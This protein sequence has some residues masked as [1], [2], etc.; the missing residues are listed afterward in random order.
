[1]TTGTGSLSERAVLVSRHI[2]LWTARCRDKSVE[3]EVGTAHATAADSGNY[4]KKLL[5]EQS[6]EYAAIVAARNKVNAIFNDPVLSM[7]WDGLS[8][9]VVPAP[10]YPTYADRMRQAVDTFRAAVGPFVAVY[11]VLTEQAR[12]RLNGL[13]NATDYP[14]PQD[15][16]AMFAVST[17]VDALVDTGSDFRVSLGAQEREYLRQ[18]VA[19]RQQAAASA[20]LRAFCVVLREQ[21]RMTRDRLGAE[22]QNYTNSLLDGLQELVDAAESMNLSDDAGLAQVAQDIR[23]KVLQHNIRDIRSDTDAAVVARAQVVTDAQAILDVMAG[24]I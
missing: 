14:H 10:L 7:P 21:V 3:A 4:W 5:P 18:E 2:S 19:A 15:V 11:P 1:M 12:A 22:K 9:R 16:A 13:W 17:A 6:K 24:M 23:E 20:S 8:V